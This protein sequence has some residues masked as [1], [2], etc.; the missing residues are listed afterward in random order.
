[1]IHKV[2]SSFLYSITLIITASNCPL[3]LRSLVVLV[4]I[5]FDMAQPIEFQPLLLLLCNI[6]QLYLQTVLPNSLGMKSNCRIEPSLVLL[7]Q[8]H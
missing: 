3:N 7:C 8:C 1:M 5:Q 6:K 4:I 2:T